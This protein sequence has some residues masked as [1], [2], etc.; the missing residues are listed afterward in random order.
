ML[1]KWNEVKPEAPAKGKIILL[2][3]KELGNNCRFIAEAYGPDMSIC[4]PNEVPND[5][6][7]IIRWG[8]TSNLP[9]TNVKRKVLNEAKAIHETSDKRSFRLLCDKHGLTSKTWPSFQALQAEE[10]V[11]VEAVIFRPSHHE[12]SQNIFLCRTLDEA[13]KALRQVEGK[14]YYISEYIPK[15]REIRVFVAFGRAFMAFEK[16]P[17]NKKDVSWG[18]VE[19]GA[20]KYI[21]WSE[22][23]IA[24]VSNAIK[25]F[26]LSKL[27]FG[28]ADIMMKDGKA[29]FLEFNTAPEVWPYY[30]ERFSDVFKH[31][32]NKNDYSRIPVKDWTTWKGLIHPV[33][34]DKAIV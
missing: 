12:R 16:I 30:G 33:L 7:V 29:Y 27:D 10:E 18:C 31:H 34:S 22:W 3:R 28:A 24:A 19:E 1:N 14:E 2:R 25:A 4:M 23:P 21:P 6:K 20:L 17:K 8:T 9:V 15:D 26:N 13:K 32:I 11:N 5:A